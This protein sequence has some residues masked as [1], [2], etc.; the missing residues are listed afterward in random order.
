MAKLEGNKTLVTIAADGTLK[1]N[2]LDIAKFF[3]KQHRK[4]VRSIEELNC[5]PEFAAANFGL[6][7][8]IHPQNGKQY[9]MYEMTRDGFSFLVMG[10]TGI[11]AAE[12]KEKYIAAFNEMEKQLRDQTPAIPQTFPEALRLAADN[13]ERAVEAEK[14]LEIAAPKAEALERISEAEGS[15]TIRKAAKTLQIR[16]K[17]LTDYLKS[18]SWIY[19]EASNGKWSGFATKINQKLLE[20][21]VEEVEVK[22]GKTKLVSQV[23]ITP[24][25]LTRL[26]KEIGDV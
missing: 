4:V 7:P 5:S 3:N 11:D 12:W 1:A 18:N 2:S 8:F 13:M 23:R 14:A 22:A 19:K 21:K 25:G 24:K 15:L 9:K 6:T 20:H 26:A 10:F 16:P 17:D